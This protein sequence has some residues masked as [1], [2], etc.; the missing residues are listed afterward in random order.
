MSDLTKF[1]DHCRAMATAEHKPECEWW[2]LGLV[3]ATNGQRI[4]FE[5]LFDEPEGSR[6]RVV[7]CLG[8]VSDSDRALFGLLAAEVDDYLAPQPDLFGDLTAEP[9]PTVP[10]PQTSEQEA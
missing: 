1:R 8:C 10:A 5:R 7:H 9:A 3:K 2:S 4:A 6:G